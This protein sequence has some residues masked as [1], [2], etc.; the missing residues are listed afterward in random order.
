MLIK[1]K[2]RAY[3]LIAFVGR[4]DASTKLRQKNF[5]FLV[6]EKYFYKLH[7]TLFGQKQA[8]NAFFVEVLLVLCQ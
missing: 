8:K 2:K 4:S 5:V 1:P 7:T 6:C 3:F